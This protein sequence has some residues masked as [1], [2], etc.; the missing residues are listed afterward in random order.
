MLTA[1]LPVFFKPSLVSNVIYPDD[2]EK[3][4]S[5]LAFELIGFF[6]NLLKKFNSWKP[7]S[8]LAFALSFLLEDE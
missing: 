3:M 7:P 8:P 6:L 1:D 5:E 4:A 2:S